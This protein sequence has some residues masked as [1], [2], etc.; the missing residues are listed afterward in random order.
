[1]VHC[2]ATTSELIRMS[3]TKDYED[4]RCASLVPLNA[5]HVCSDLHPTPAFAQLMETAC[6][7]TPFYR[8][9]AV[10]ST[11]MSHGFSV[12]EHQSY[13][14]RCSD[15]CKVSGKGKYKLAAAVRSYLLS[16]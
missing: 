9:T 3:L 10:W 16:P 1:V 4:G 14:H 6:P 15:Q 12:I 11:N 7:E 13:C 2:Q 8:S 5:M